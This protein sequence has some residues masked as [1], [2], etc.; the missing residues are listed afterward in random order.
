MVAVA[1]MVVVCAGI[2]VN[3]VAA[4]VIRWRTIHP[5]TRGGDSMGRPT[6]EPRVRAPQDEKPDTDDDEK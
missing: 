2:V 4:V 6:R 3:L 5:P 1:T